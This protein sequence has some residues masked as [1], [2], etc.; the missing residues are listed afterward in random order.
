MKKLISALLMAPFI[1]GCAHDTHWI[2]PAAAGVVV[3]AAV[4]HSSHHRAPQPHYHHYPSR[5]TV[6]YSHPYSVPRPVIY[7]PY[8][9]CYR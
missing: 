5:P 9:R 6:Y 1:V 3:G 7:D 8:C 4:M 2:V